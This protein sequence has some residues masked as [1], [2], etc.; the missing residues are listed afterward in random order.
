MPMVKGSL[1]VQDPRLGRVPELDPRNREY[2]IGEPL[3][4]AAPRRRFR[5]RRW[6]VPS[7]I[8]LNQG[9]E[10][11]CVSFGNGHEAISTPT[12]IRGPERL[13]Y[14]WLVKQY[15]IM[16]H[17][18][19]WDGC[20]LGRSCPVEPGPQYGGTS[21]ESGLRRFRELG[22]FKEYRWGFGI[23]DTAEG[24]GRFA[25][26]LVGTDWFENWYTVGERMPA[27]K[28][29]PVGGHLYLLLGI[30]IPS[31]ERWL[32]GDFLVL[33]SWGPTWGVDGV[34][35]ISVRAFAKV[36]ENRG[37]CAFWLRRTFHPKGLAA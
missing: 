20:S 14:D 3:R 28:G 21:E 18:D 2:P 9:Q 35:R 25:P 23:E 24:V 27:P 16:Q 30:E 6:S 13:T 11:A 5:T 22:F 17:E 37:T 19:P 7:G 36:L 33:N 4:Q 12:A 1:E 15:H 26:A 31:P 10:G 32:D 34:S 8:V 29:R